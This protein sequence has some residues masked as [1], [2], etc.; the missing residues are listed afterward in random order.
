MLLHDAGIEVVECF[1]TTDRAHKY[2]VLVLEKKIRLIA[3]EKVM[4]TLLVRHG[5]TRKALMGGEAITSH[6][7]ADKELSLAQNVSFQWIMK[8][9]K[10]HGPHIEEYV[11]TG[12]K[13]IIKAFEKKEKSFSGIS[14]LKKE[15]IIRMYKSLEGKLHSSES[16]LLEAQQT[17]RFVTSNLDA[18]I[19]A[20]KVYTEECKKM[21]E[22][23]RAAEAEISELKKHTPVS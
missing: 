18:M 1:T 20:N 21:K 14:E 5:I 9:L 12:R 13:S 10:E 23:L 17:I 15:Q 19:V 11:A 16:E 2:T 3:I 7:K 8:D 22:R 6:K 4:G